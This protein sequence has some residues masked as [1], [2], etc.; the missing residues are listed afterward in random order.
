MWIEMCTGTT[1]TPSCSWG[2]LRAHPPQWILP[3]G[4][5][6]TVDSTAQK[7][8]ADLLLKRY[9]PSP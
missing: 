1:R 4:G 2:A 7:L 9:L 5:Q 3:Y 8:W 6:V